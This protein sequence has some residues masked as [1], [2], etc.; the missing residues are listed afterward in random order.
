MA[1]IVTYIDHDFAPVKIGAGWSCILNYGDT[2][3]PLYVEPDVVTLTFRNSKGCIRKTLTN[4]DGITVTFA[5]NI[6]TMAPV[7]EVSDIS[8]MGV[9]VYDIVLKLEWTGINTVIP[10]VGTFTIEAAYP[11]TT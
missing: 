4:A 8:A 1:T 7:L 2:T 11:A 9:G 10:L 3:N 5:D 6:V